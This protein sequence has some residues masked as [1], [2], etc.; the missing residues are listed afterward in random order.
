MSWQDREGAP[1]GQEIW[2]QIDATARAA[3]DE[4]RAARRVVDV[5]GPLGF[6]ARAGVAR[7]ERE[8]LPRLQRVHAQPQLEHEL[9]AA[10]IARIPLG[11][12]RSRSRGAR[13]HR[14]PRSPLRS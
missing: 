6:G 4:V 11:V 12:G 3:A 9:A 2:D 5:V 13:A 1:F 8:E 7:C 14:S 10:E